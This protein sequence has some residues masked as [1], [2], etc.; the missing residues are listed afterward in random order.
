MRLLSLLLARSGGQH[1]RH[2]SVTA[3]EGRARPAQA[4][5]RHGRL[6]RLPTFRCSSNLLDSLEGARN[7]AEALVLGIFHRVGCEGRGLA[8]AIR[9]NITVI[10]LLFEQ[11][12]VW[13]IILEVAPLL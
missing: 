8:L 6:M 4:A 5:P 7:V 9:R 13:L 3:L 1:R 10:L 2:F 12:V 11:R